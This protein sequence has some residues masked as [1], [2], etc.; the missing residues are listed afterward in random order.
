MAGQK[1]KMSGDSGTD[2]DLMILIMVSIMVLKGIPNS[3]IIP[4]LAAIM[5]PILQLDLCRAMP[6]CAMLRYAM[7]CY[8]MPCYAM[9]CRAMLCHVMLCYGVHLR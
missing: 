5:I 3:N 1:Y 2:P 8:A 7:P 4:L 9:P 6:C